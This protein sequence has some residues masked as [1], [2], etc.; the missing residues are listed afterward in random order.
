MR[1]LPDGFVRDQSC[2]RAALGM[3]VPGGTVSGRVTIHRNAGRGGSVM[4]SVL[5]FRRLTIRGERRLRVL[6]ARMRALA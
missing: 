4:R 1:K 6:V 2:I 5:V 3:G